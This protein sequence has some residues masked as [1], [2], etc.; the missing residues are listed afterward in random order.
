MR[1]NHTAALKCG[2]DQATVDLR[3]YNSRIGEVVRALT[4]HQRG[5]GSLPGPADAKLS[6]CWFSIIL[7]CSEGFSLGSPDF[8]PWQK[9]AYS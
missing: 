3:S 9:P 2:N 1:K 8:L 7:F 4:S 6:L 5:P